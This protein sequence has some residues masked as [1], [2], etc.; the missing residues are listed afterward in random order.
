MLFG[1]FFRDQYDYV[2]N[3]RTGN[4]DSSWHNKLHCADWC[5]HPQEAAW[6]RSWSRTGQVG[7]DPN[8]VNH[9]SDLSIDDSRDELAE[10]VPADMESNTL[11]CT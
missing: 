2:G 1:R 9:P 8:E 5:D 11:K 3:G 7:P 6:S 10:K 4:A